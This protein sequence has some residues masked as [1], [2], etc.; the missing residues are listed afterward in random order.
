MDDTATQRAAYTAGLRHLADL[1]DI[2]PDLPIPYEGT[3][4]AI[5]LFAKTLPEAVAARRLLLPDPT[6]TV[7]H[8]NNYKARLEG[9]FDG[10]QMIVY[11]AD[12]VAFA[13]PVPIAPT[14]VPWLAGPVLS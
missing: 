12:E 8:G 11:V 1:L 10:L 7:V 2:H 9:T 4:G 5:G 13:S 3:T 6:A 14:L